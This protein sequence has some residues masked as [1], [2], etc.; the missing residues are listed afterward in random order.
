MARRVTCMSAPP[1][2]FFNFMLSNTQCYDHDYDLNLNQEPSI[3]RAISS[4]DILHT[5]PTPSN[6]THLRH[7]SLRHRVSA[8]NLSFADPLRSCEAGLRRPNAFLG[9]LFM[10]STSS[11]Q[12]QLPTL[13]PLIHTIRK[14]YSVSAQ[15]A[16]TFAR[17]VQSRGDANDVTA[18]QHI[19]A[20]TTFVSTSDTIANM[21]ASTTSSTAS[22]IVK[23]QG[24]KCSCLSTDDCS[25]CIIP[26]TV[27]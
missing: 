2:K 8:L 5:I 26:C 22:S 1:S 20:T 19:C 6:A 21:P 14:F 17:R 12:A 3:P 24:G 15:S 25:C 18:L 10:P 27:M 7:E 11:P 4:C 16:S 13:S 9:L 23:P